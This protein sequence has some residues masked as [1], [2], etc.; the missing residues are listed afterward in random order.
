MFVLCR[1]VGGEG[2]RGGDMVELAESEFQESHGE[3]YVGMLQGIKL[4]ESH[5][6]AG[7]FGHVTSAIVCAASSF[8]MSITSPAEFLKDL[9]L[10]FFKRYRPLPDKSLE[11]IDYVEPDLTSNPVRS[12][13]TSTASIGATGNEV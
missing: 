13:A 4:F 5:C 11:P 3:G 7:A 6:Q 1:A 2:E 8:S 9:G 12:E 10:E